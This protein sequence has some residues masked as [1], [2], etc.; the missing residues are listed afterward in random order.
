MPDLADWVYKL[1]QRLM[2]LTPGRWIIILTVGK[3]H[4]WTVWGPEKVERP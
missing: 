2:N 1:A 3:E 4:D